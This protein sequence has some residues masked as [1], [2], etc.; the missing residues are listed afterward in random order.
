MVVMKN[1]EARKIMLRLEKEGTR[2]T[3]IAAKVKRARNAESTENWF[4]ERAVVTGEA[5]MQKSRARII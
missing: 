5:W 1:R 2:F 3:R 4:T